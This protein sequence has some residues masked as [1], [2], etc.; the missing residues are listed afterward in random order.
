MSA[1]NLYDP[2]VIRWRP[3][4][5][6]R[7]A[8]LRELAELRAAVEPACAALTASRPDP[9][10]RDELTTHDRAMDA[11]AREG[12]GQAYVTADAAFHRVLLTESGSGM[13]A[14]LAEVTEVLLEARRELL[15]L[16]VRLETTAIGLHHEIAEAVAA[17]RAAEA[18]QT[19]ADIVGR[20]RAEV[21]QILAD[22][23][24]HV[25]EVPR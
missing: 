23:R 25:T 12:D 8:Q 11:A 22:S 24:K 7:E 10:V 15:L 6:G 20:A 4:S 16:P 2:Q 9:R 21:E 19:A 1:W 13:F 18:A 17:G 14:Q 5:P 3:A